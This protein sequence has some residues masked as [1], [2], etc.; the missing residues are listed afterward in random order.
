MKLQEGSDQHMLWLRRSSADLDEHL[1]DV[2]PC[3]EPGEGDRHLVEALQ[4]L[5]TNQHD[6]PQQT[7]R[8]SR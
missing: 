2:L 5:H 6:E 3:E 4:H 7:S 8:S 1:A